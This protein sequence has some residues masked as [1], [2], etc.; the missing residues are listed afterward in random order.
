MKIELKRISINERM[1][2]ETT[3]FVADVYV[4]GVNV[5]E[6]K[7]DGHGGSTF[8]YAGS[9][10]GN[11]QLVAKAE[12]Y[13]KT[14]PDIHYPDMN[15]SLKSDL[16]HIVDDLVFAEQKKKD[17]KKLEKKME[18]SI[19]FG[20]PNSGTYSQ[21]SFKVPLSSMSKAEL[22]GYVV[23]YKSKFKKGEV[24]LNTNFE[25]LGITV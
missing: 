5:G 3:C 17:A 11:R 14:L 13:A 8:V 19:M 24:F 20:V 7:N 15:F 25:K 2:E 4:D 10:P 21:I 1:S 12:A 16:E 22:Q 23:Q 6:A 9:A 18:K